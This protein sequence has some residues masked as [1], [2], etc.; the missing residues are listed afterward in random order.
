MKNRIE[1][2]GKLEQA[3]ERTVE[4]IFTRAF[5]ARIQ[6]VEIAKRLCREMDNRRTISVN[7]VYAPNDFAVYLHPSDL[8]SFAPFLSSLLPELERYLADR[9]R[10]Q[11]YELLG[12]PRVVLEGDEAVRQGEMR[13]VARTAD[14]RAQPQAGAALDMTM[15]QLP[16]GPCLEVT[17]GPDAGR[18]YRLDRLPVLLGR[19]SDTEIRLSDRGVSRRHAR[20]E[21]EGD[22]LILSDLGSTNGTYVG[23]ERIT[24]HRLQDGDQ[25]RIAATTLLFRQVAGDG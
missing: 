23:E 14:L 25:V 19:G 15:V 16:A 8:E 5:R 6:P 24:R 17:A 4:S 3:L 10:T 11:G 7:R 13:V 12:G 20:I 21:A 1:F 18:H 22:D 9:A 2:L